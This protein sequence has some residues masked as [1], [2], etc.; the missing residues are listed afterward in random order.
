MHKIESM[1]IVFTENEITLLEEII[2]SHIW[3]ILAFPESFN[4]EDELLMQNHQMFSQGTSKYHFTQIQDHW[5]DFFT[6]SK[7]REAPAL[8][9]SLYKKALQTEDG[10]KILFEPI[11]EKIHIRNEENSV[12]YIYI[13]IF[14]SLL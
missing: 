7:Q 11:F 13:Y 12:I 14:N 9:V 10:P 1:R 4:I 3:N 6:P 8:L 2:V 5:S